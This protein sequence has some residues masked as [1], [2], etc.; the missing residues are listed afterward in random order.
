[1]TSLRDPAHPHADEF[2]LNLQLFSG[3]RETRDN[4]HPHPHHW[5]SLHGSLHFSFVP[6]Y[7]GNVQGSTTG[8]L[9]VMEKEG[10][11][12]KN[13]HSILGRLGSYLQGLSRSSFQWFRY[14]QKYR[15]AV[16]P[17]NLVGCRSVWVKCWNEKY[18]STHTI[19]HSSWLVLTEKLIGKVWGFP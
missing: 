7:N 6:Q 2:F 10:G 15:D 16:W 12:S 3:K 18:G 5:R 13:H 11:Y 17:E 4:T 9:I 1:M 14:L 19:E 8:N